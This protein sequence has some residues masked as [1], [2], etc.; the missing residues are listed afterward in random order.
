VA[1]DIALGGGRAGDEQV[2]AGKTSDCGK[3]LSHL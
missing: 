2:Q 1:D 3:S